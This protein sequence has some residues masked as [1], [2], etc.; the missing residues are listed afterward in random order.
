LVFL[1]Y[2]RAAT[3]I[4]DFSHSSSTHEDVVGFEVTMYYVLLVSVGESLGDL[5]A[6][7]HLPELIQFVFNV[8][9]EVAFWAVLS[10]EID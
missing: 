10:D 2:L 1:F 8:V 5:L 7:L 6:D 9:L 3:E 4:A